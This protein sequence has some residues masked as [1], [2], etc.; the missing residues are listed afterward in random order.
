MEH[1]PEP[2]AR[3]SVF[4]LRVQAALTARGIH[5]WVDQ[6]VRIWKV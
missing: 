4:V 2:Q 5:V 3:V 6:T 1:L